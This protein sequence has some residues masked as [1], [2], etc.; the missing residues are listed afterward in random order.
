MKSCGRYLRQN[1][2]KAGLWALLC[3]ALL[4]GI[5][6]YTKHLAAAYLSNVRT[7]VFIEGVLDFSLV[8]NPGAAWGMLSGGRWFFVATTFVV[9]GYI[10]YYYPKMPKKR[11]GAWG[12]AG[13]VLL[14][15]GAAGNLI[16]RLRNEGGYVIDF[17]RVRFID[18]PVFNMADIYVVT[19]ACIL[20]LTVVFFAKEDKA[21]AKKSLATHQGTEDSA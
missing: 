20:V 16:D 3:I 10:F 17:L 5:D 18:F 1:Y 19:G 9:L 12:K 14:S 21:A 8:K 13:F 11:S 2:G 15:A 6:Q 7:I 4:I